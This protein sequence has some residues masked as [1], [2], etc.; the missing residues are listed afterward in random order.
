MIQSQEKLIASLEDK[1]KN[2]R[3][4][5]SN[6]PDKSS[7]EFIEKCEFIISQLPN[8]TATERIIYNHYLD[9]K[10]TKEVMKEMSITEN[11]LKFHNKNI[12]GKLSDSSRKQLIEYGKVI[13][14]KNQ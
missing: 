9:G 10:S 4:T 6:I 8:L 1:M 3:E 14:K 2:S 7:P 5:V 13:S 11:T 12:Y